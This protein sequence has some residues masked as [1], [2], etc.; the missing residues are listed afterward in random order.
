MEY[1]KILKRMNDGRATGVVDLQIAMPEYMVNELLELEQETK[2][3]VEELVFR[4]IR[5]YID[6]E[7]SSEMQWWIKGVKYPV[8]ERLR[9]P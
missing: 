9:I 1:V 4:A 3:S 5:R 7:R 6:C 2:V 8:P